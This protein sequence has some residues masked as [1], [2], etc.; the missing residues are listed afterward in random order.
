VIQIS[1]AGAAAIWLPVKSGHNARAKRSPDC[2][3]PTDAATTTKSA[4]AKRI[5]MGSRAAT[6]GRG[7]PIRIR[8]V[9]RAIR[10]RCSDHRAC[11][12]GSPMPSAS[13][14]SSVW[15]GLW[16]NPLAR[17]SLR[18]AWSASGSRIERNPVH[19][20]KTRPAASATRITVWSQT[21]SAGRTPNKASAMKPAMIISDGQSPRQ[22]PSQVIIARARKSFPP[23]RTSFRS[24]FRGRS[25]IERSYSLGFTTRR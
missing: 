1:S 11:V 22:S 4:A 12:S 23:Y 14:S 19:S 17:S 15:S 18:R 6:P 21:G 2:G 5:A 9:A 25:F 16:A 10:L 3:H 13:R 8:R 7:S 20:A 24:L